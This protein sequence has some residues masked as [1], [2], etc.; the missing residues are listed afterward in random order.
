MARGWQY[1]HAAM[2]LAG[3]RVVESA[4]GVGAE[5]ERLR[6]ELSFHG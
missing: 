5:I 1:E 4:A 2:V 3:A 6:K